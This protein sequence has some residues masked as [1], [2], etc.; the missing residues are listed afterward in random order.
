MFDPNITSSSVENTQTQS[1]DNA[2]IF[3]L[4]WLL[5]L[6]LNTVRFASEFAFEL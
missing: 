6:I 4:P 1:N 3:L 2:V 5:S